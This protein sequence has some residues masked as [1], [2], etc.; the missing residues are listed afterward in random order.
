MV[1]KEECPA[2]ITFRLLLK[3]TGILFKICNVLFF[4]CFFTTGSANEST[5]KPLG[6][7]NDNATPQKKGISFISQYLL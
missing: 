1:F 4:F 3:F 7:H 2:I 5:R 6:N